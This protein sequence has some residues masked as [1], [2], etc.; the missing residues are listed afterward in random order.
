MRK[1]LLLLALL[2]IMV[3][4]A[5]AQQRVVAGEVISKADGLPIIGAAIV[6]KGDKSIGTVTDL[7][8][9]F[10]LPIPLS[11][12]TLIVSYI[13]LKTMEVPVVGDY[14]KIE[15]QE[16]AQVLQDVVVVGMTKVDKRL[17][18]GASTKVSGDKSK[19][20]GMAD[21]T[22][23]LEGKAAGVSVQNVSGTF[24]SAPKIR[25]RGATSIYGASKPLWVVD[26][27]VMDD[28]VDVDADALASGDATTLISS[29][30]AGLN[31]DDIES[32]QVL[33]DGSATSI[34][35]AR[36]MAGVIAVTTKKGRSGVSKI[37]YTGEYT[38]R[39]KPSYRDFN[40]MNSQQQMG[41]YREMEEKGWMLNADVSNAP[42]SGIYGKMWQLVNRGE[43]EN[44]E[45]ARNA[46]LRQGEYRNTD[47]F[48]LL[49]NHNVMNNHSV[50]VTSGTD[51]ISYYASMSALV[52]P[53]WTEQS[54]VNRYT[55]NLNTT[56]KIAGNLSLNLL[57]NAALRT[58]T[59]PGTLSQNT[60][61]VTGEVSRDFD[62]N[63]YS[64]SL[65]TSRVLDPMEN[66]V[67]SFA[68]F[69]IFRELD[70]NY[71]RLK[72]L[73]L[74]FQGEMKW[75]PIRGLELSVLG[76]IKHSGSNNEHTITEMSNQAMAQRAM[77]TTTIRDANPY[78][79]RD[80]D[81]I[82]AD[83][84][85]VLPVGG[86]L[87]K[88]SYS[89]LAWDFRTSASFNREFGSGIL[90]LFGGIEIN[91]IDRHATEDHSVG[92]LFNKGNI[93]HFDPLYFKRMREEAGQ[94]TGIRDSYYRNVAFFVNTTYNYRGKYTVNGTLRYEG[95]NKMGRSTSAR[96]LPTWN[97]SGSWHVEQ[98]KF[99][100]P[101]RSA[102]PSLTLKGSYS[103]TA[104][105]GPSFVTNSTIIIR[106]LTPW[107]SEGSQQ[108]SGFFIESPENSELTY[109]KK[110]ELNFGLDVALLKN[111]LNLSLDWYN[112]RNFDLIGPTNTMGI[113][114]HNI[115]FG[116]V[117]SMHSNGLEISISSTNYKSQDFKWITDFVYTHTRNKVTYLDN[118]S[119]VIDL[120]TGSG[121]ARQGYPV[122]AIFSIP[123]M[124]LDSYGLPTFA[125]PEGGV[126]ST[127]INFQERE[128]IDYLK[129]EGSADPTDFGSLGN[130]LVYKNWRLNAFLTYSFGNVV[131]L[132]PVF[133][134]EYNDLS[135]MPREF[136]NRWVQPG[137]EQRTDIPVIASLLQAYETTNIRYA[138][139]A[140]NYSDRRIAR[141]DF[142]RLKEVSLAY[143][144]PK[145]W[146]KKLS[147]ADLS[148][149]LQASNLML[150]YSDAKLNGQ[151]P[152]FFNTGGVATPLP[153]QI[154]M[155]L[156]VGI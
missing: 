149:K 115:K 126:T 9:K 97:L 108:E 47:W 71:L 73:D 131:R 44:T 107:R 5:S 61:P 54:K 84:I 79:Y 114:G 87:N 105:K 134:S 18:T 36:A 8:G 64:F 69:N 78:L 102:I 106:S 22:R 90:N 41:V 120:I 127:E 118:H 10:K 42:S 39:L 96:W 95:T 85:S 117:A 13:G 66:Y 6:V 25:V 145:S 49:F 72:V 56:Y 29:A 17:F 99:F 3:A 146:V 60:N 20:D 74:K 103:L 67:R 144:F 92:V 152:E 109:E 142:I 7:D 70:N 75:S 65:N 121:F 43:L 133:H 111:R 130:T 53:G 38:Y 27:V 138:Y 24:G 16:D 76:D 136:E 123:F 80:P 128:R 116:N 98:E 137:D 30:I 110:H 46:F 124:G 141:G 35:G 26:G 59:A 45:Q 51:K 151:D 88:T 156:R 91:S 48:D 135:S 119:R 34:Y 58:Q 140:F 122:R 94:Y 125:T 62:I 57:A 19:M 52:D 155:T 86:I 55:A 1:Y 153:R 68:P 32:F 12:K 148:L 112:R 14:L 113:G 83:P 89:L 50:S 15:M 93:Q 132:D 2:P 139:N 37:S 4:I 154:T 150:L 23:A 104:D 147:I 28:V 11:T 129:Y 40:I 21:A 77:E 31:P 63:P 82:Y 101:L 81:N 143:D 100:A 33:K